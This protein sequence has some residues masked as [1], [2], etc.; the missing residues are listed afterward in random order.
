MYSSL[1]DVPNDLQRCFPFF[2]GG[3]EQSFGTADVCSSTEDEANNWSDGSEDSRSSMPPT[4]FETSSR[5]TIEELINATE[6]R[7][8]I[9]DK[10]IARLAASGS[11][12]QF[13]RR[14]RRAIHLLK[15]GRRPLN[16][17]THV[18]GPRI[19]AG[20]AHLRPEV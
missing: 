17:H 3:P 10:Q 20:H 5:I 11:K 7:P 12:S 18:K 14:I 16:A 2:L 1:L 19:A 15:S 4:R 6:T 13:S 8:R 9:S